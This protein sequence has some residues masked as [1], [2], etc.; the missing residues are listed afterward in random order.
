MSSTFQ[1]DCSVAARPP[2]GTVSW[3]LS[4]LALPPAS[5]PAGRG[6]PAGPGP[7]SPFLALG[8]ASPSPSPEGHCRWGHVPSP[9]LSPVTGQPPPSRSRRG[10]CRCCLLAPVPGTE[11]SGPSVTRLPSS[12]PRGAGSLP[13]SGQAG[14]LALPLPFLQPSGPPPL[15]GPGGSSPP[16]GSVSVPMLCASMTEGSSWSLPREASAHRQV[17]CRRVCPERFVGSLHGQAL[18]GST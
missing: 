1:W 2:E 8:P 4:L 18:G 11:S 7:A 6:R 17:P 9:L 15:H 5:P 12:L 3:P 16:R 13:G 10:A 14:I